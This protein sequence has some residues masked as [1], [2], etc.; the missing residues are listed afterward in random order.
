VDRLVDGGY[1]E[2][3]GLATAADLVW[4]L[5][6]ADLDPVVVSVTNDPIVEPGSDRKIKSAGERPVLPDQASDQLSG[7][8]TAILFA[9]YQTRQ[10]HQEG[11]YGYLESS[12]RGGNR[13]FAV[14]VRPLEGFSGRLCRDRGGPVKYDKSKRRAVL[15]DVS[16]SWW[17]SQPV[18]AYLDGQL[19]EA[20][21]TDSL[22]CEL[23]NKGL[24][25][26]GCIQK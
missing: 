23:A 17:V 25:E 6:A 12:M 10:G 21:N 22:A 14:G 18:Q 7:G 1:F 4:A 5:R 26:P 9:L 8:F 19:C 24:G 3:G 11:S 15:D 2:N 16:M 13:Y 20:K